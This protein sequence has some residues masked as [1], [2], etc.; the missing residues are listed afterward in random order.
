MIKSSNL[1]DSALSG[2]SSSEII[3]KYLV[4]DVSGPDRTD[5]DGSQIAAS[6][7]GLIDQ[8]AHQV[9]YLNKDYVDQVLGQLR[10]GASA[11][12]MAAVARY[13][14][15]QYTS[16]GANIGNGDFESWDLI[17]RNLISLATDQLP[18]VAG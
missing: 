1:I 12:E 4:D 6:F 5:L 3:E 18:P 13:N 14:R 10:Q 8:T 17:H 15:D 2:V 7:Q 9:P 11:D 16:E